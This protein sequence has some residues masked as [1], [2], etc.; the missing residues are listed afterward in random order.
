MYDPA[1]ANDPF[2]C[3]RTISAANDGGKWTFSETGERFAFEDPTAYRRRL[4]CDRFTPEMLAQY[5]AKLGVPSDQ[6]PDTRS[7]ILV[8]ES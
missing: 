2:L 8:E 3:R 7:G 5:L 4:V 6:E 1:A